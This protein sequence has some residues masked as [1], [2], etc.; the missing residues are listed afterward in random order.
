MNDK[1]YGVIEQRISNYLT[2]LKVEGL[3]WHD[4]KQRFKFTEWEKLKDLT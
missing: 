3:K 2:I 4:S 1:C